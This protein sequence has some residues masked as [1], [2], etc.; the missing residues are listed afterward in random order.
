MKH[1]Q[2]SLLSIV[3]PV[4]DTGL[5]L[6]ACLESILQQDY[7]NWELLAV[8]DHSSDNSLSILKAYALLDQ[9]VR[10]YA[11]SGSGIIEALQTAYEHSKG[12]Y[13]TRMDSDD[14]MHPT[15]LTGLYHALLSSKNS[16]S[17]AV[18][19]VE[20]FSDTTLGEGYRAYAQW[21]ND[22]TSTATNFSDIYRECS[23]P[24]P[25]WMCS[26]ETLDRAGGFN[27]HIYPEDYDLAFRMRS[28][29]LEILPVNQ[30]I[31]Y[32]RDYHNRTSRTDPNYSDNRFL[33]LKIKYF[34]EQDHR[35][36]L[37]LIL[38]GA[39][40]KGKAIA[41]ALIEARVDFNWVCNNPNKIG[42]D[43]YGVVLYGVEYLDRLQSGQVIRSISARHDTEG[44]NNTV[45]SNRQ[46]LFYQFS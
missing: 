21:L 3:M 28:L 23:I 42:H 39:G 46:L 6:V 33:E 44:T 43:I 13:I 29:D 41:K 37:D 32:W 34:L 18:G 9:R 36:G 27:S 19:L 24:S 12:S 8:D 11:N 5:Y 17:I 4:K 20:Y 14:I 40:R 38:W 26:R 35:H 1:N 31:H 30:V 15:K 7:E 22:L 16:A 25:C 2:H 10:V 45:T